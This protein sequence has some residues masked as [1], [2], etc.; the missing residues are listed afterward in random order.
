M[1]LWHSEPSPQLLLPYG[2]SIYQ[3]R[4]GEYLRSRDADRAKRNPLHGGIHTICHLA[5]RI[6][7]SP[8]HPKTFTFRNHLLW[9]KHWYQDNQ[10]KSARD[11]SVHYVVS[12]CPLWP[13]SDTFSHWVDFCR[14]PRARRLYR[15]KLS[16]HNAFSLSLETLTA[17]IFI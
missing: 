9:D 2:L 5:S 13:N 11:H 6:W 4:L 15:D 1:I 8:H 10:A 7:E 12:E 17:A 16:S 3:Y 14:N